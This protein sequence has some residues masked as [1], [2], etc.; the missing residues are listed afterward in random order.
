MYI[1]QPLTLQK[2]QRDFPECWMNVFPSLRHANQNVKELS[3][4]FIK[5]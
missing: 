5:E 2:D 1:R 3:I 4:L